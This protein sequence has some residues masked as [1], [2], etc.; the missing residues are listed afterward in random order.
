LPFRGAVGYEESP[1]T[2][3]RL[4]AR[5]LHF[6]QDRLFASLRMTAKRSE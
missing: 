1:V 5:F 6:V 2:S 3:K 4:R